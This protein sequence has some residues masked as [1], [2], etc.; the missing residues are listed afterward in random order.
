MDGEEIDEGCKREGGKREIVRLQAQQRS[1]DQRGHHGGDERCQRQS[2][3]ARRR[4][5]QRHDIGAKSE[6]GALRQA[7]CAEL[8][9][10]ELIAHAHQGVDANQSHHALTERRQNDERHEQRQHQ[11]ECP[12]PAEPA[13]R[14]ARLPTG[15]PNRP[16][17]RRTSTAST[18]M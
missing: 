17:G 16:C 3:H 8:A 15:S 13:H 9:E 1:A 10:H 5:K 12:E 7:E 4:S 6:K 14:Q 18:A 2:E 11:D